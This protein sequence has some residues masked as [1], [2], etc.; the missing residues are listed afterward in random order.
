M[1]K[2]QERDDSPATY[3]VRHILVTKDSLALPEGEE[4]TEELL[5]AK[6]EEI[7]DTWDGTEEGFAKL[8]EENSKDPGSNTTGG[9]YEDVAKGQRVAAFQD[10]CYE[11]G[12]KSGDT[13]L[14]YNAS[15]G[16]HIIYVVGY[17]DEQNG[18]YN[19]ENALRSADASEW[20]SGLIASASAEI[21]ES[22]MKNVG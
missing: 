7:L 10:W 19:C 9:L 4:A 17:G 16:Y 3:N 11:D 2:R 5:K 21:N 8:A 6:A 20:Q 18:H 1:Y 22:G 13:G 15:T 14:V 12:R